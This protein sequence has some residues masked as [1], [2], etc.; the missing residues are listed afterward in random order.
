VPSS[1]SLRGF[2]D[3]HLPSGLV[4]HVCSVHERDGSRWL[5]MPTKPQI[6]Q[7]RK[8]AETGKLTYSRVVEIVNKAL[9]VRFHAAALAAVERPLG[10][11]AGSG[12]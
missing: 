10:T 9:R 6:G 5:G 2:V 12:V 3:L 1:S 8:D 7:H 11:G 4:I